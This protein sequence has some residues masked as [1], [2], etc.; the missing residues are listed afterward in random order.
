MKLN[1]MQKGNK[2]NKNQN[3]LVNL[4]MYLKLLILLK[5]INKVTK[6]VT[7]INKRIVKNKIHSHI[8][9]QQVTINLDLD[10]K[11]LM[12]T[13][14]IV[15][16]FIKIN[17]VYILLFSMILNIIKISILIWIIIKKT[18]NEIYINNIQLRL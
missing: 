14:I 2:F 1:T 3:K 10:Y 9:I 11:S 4:I 7:H 13:N 18:N 16:I 8:K 5:K 6:I 12:N 17:Q 15:M